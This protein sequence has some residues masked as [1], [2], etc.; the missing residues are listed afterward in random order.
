MLNYG[1]L[2]DVIPSTES[3]SFMNRYMAEQDIG[4][5]VEETIAKL[6]VWHHLPTPGLKIASFI[7]T[8]VLAEPDVLE[9]LSPA[10]QSKA[11]MVQETV[12]RRSFMMRRAFQRC[13]VKNVTQFSGPLSKVEIKHERDKAPTCIDAPHISLSFS[14]SNAV[15]IAASSHLGSIGV[16]IET[17][18]IIPNTSEL[19]T[20][21]FDKTEAAYLSSLPDQIREIEFIKFWTVK[22]A[23][24]KAIGKGVIFG[25]DKFKVTPRDGGYA[26]DPPQEYGVRKEWEVIELKVA[27]RAMATVASHRIKTV[28]ISL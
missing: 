17:R 7:D 2:C 13:F 27:E 5:K 18:R 19:A 3:L 16:D 22:E 23:C 9:T 1:A 20:R 6:M 21:F 25:L 15:A 24:L 11:S 14:S 10:E 8:E 12:E 28:E 26:V 4:T